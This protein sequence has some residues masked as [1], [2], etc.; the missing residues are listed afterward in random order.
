MSANIPSI[1]DISLKNLNIPFT[2]LS[3]ARKVKAAF[4]LAIIL[5]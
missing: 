3:S 5:P 2:S 1:S 4:I